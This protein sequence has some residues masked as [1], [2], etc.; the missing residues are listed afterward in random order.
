M[1]VG[2]YIGTEFIGCLLYADN[3]ILLSPSSSIVGLQRMLD[4]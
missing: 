3:I 2:C 4:K 1:S